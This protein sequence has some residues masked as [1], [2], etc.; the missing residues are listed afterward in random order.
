MRKL[1][2]LLFTTCHQPIHDDVVLVRSVAEQTSSKRDVSALLR[3]ESA[4]TRTAVDAPRHAGIGANGIV[5]CAQRERRRTDVFGDVSSARRVVIVI[6]R[7]KLLVNRQNGVRVEL[8]NVVGAENQVKI[9][10]GVRT[11]SL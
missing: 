11:Q 2:K 5:S 4:Q 10:V 9:N 1:Q 6:H 7:S 3:Q 8:S